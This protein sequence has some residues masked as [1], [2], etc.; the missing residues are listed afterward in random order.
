MILK[1]LKDC[2]C[3]LVVEVKNVLVLN[4]LVTDV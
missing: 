2:Y 1:K 4:Y 3:L